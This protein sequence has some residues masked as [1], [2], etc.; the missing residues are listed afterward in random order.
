MDL[1]DESMSLREL[2]WTKWK[3]NQLTRKVL[4]PEGQ[5][6]NHEL[7]VALLSIFQNHS[8]TYF[9]IDNLLRLFR[10]PATS[11][12]T[13]TLPTTQHM[14]LKEFISYDSNT[15]L[16]WGCGSCCQLSSGRCPRTEC[17]ASNF[18]EAIFVEVKIDAQ[19]KERLKGN[20]SLYCLIHFT[21]CM[22]TVDKLFKYRFLEDGFML[23]LYNGCVYQDQYKFF[24]PSNIFSLI[25]K[26]D[27][28]HT[29]T[30][31][32]VTSKI[33]VCGIQSQKLIHLI[34]ISPCKLNQFSWIR[35]HIYICFLTARGHACMHAMYAHIYTCTPQND[36]C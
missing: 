36:R 10:C 33:T 27:M 19:L 25:Y 14:L 32:W 6:S 35:I 9:A 16:H 26:G 17:Q 2:W 12:Y 1:L 22:Y 21:D 24:D 34:K 23:D 4:F 15:I 29:A 5:L 31:Q 20:I 8:L 7:C 30:Y 28:A 3:L 13:S 18:Q 11:K